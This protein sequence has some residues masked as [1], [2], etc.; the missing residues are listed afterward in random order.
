MTATSL[1][2]VAMKAAG[3]DLGEVCSRLVDDVARNH[4]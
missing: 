4:G 2:P 1:V 3:L